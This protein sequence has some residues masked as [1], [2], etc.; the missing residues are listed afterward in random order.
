[1]AE[2]LVQTEIL[3]DA[4]PRLRQLGAVEKAGVTGYWSPRY[5]VRIVVTGS[6]GNYTLRYYEGGCGCGK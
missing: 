3:R 6:A 1:M 2:R 5:K 4:A